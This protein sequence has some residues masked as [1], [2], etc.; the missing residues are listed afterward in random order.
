MGDLGLVSAAGRHSIRGSGNKPLPTSLGLRQRDFAFQCGKVAPFF[1]P[2]NI[3]LRFL[4]TR[5]QVKTSP[6][7]KGPRFKLRTRKH[8]RQATLKRVYL[9]RHQALK[10]RQPSAERVFSGDWT[11]PGVH[12]RLKQRDRFLQNPGSFPW[13]LCSL[14][15]LRRVR[16]AMAL[17]NF[18]NH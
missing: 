13:H 1:F 6:L 4:N 16:L 17:V 7:Q 9:R 18:S 11:C 8:C 14:V 3:L 12:T 2:S 5:S 10:V 15:C